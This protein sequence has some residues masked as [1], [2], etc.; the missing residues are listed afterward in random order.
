MFPGIFS[1]RELTIAPILNLASRP[2]GLSL[3]LP[4]HEAPHSI[5][6]HDADLRQHSQHN[7]R[8]NI[9]RK[10]VKRHRM[11]RIRRR[12]QIEAGQQRVNDA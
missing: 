10:H 11:A 3:P 12:I 6:Q 9:A 4:R 8:R 1:S 5:D 7:I 2:R